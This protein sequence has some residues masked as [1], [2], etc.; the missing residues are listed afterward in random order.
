MSDVTATYNFAHR[1]IELVGTHGT[2]VVGVGDDTAYGPIKSINPLRCIAVIENALRGDYEV[3]WED[4]VP[5]P[6]GE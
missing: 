1:T 5:L 3:A 6:P 2:A 4:I